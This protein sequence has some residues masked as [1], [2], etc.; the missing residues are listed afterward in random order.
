MLSLLVLGLSSS[1]PVLLPHLPVKLGSVVN[2]VGITDME[3]TGQGMIDNPVKESLG[4]Q[5]AIDNVEVNNR[6]KDPAD[7]ACNDLLPC[8]IVQMD[9]MI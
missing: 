7:S 3:M 1:S 2:R 5:D 8:V 4:S 9:A 6:K